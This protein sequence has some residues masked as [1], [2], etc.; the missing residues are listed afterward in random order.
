MAKGLGA[1]IKVANICKYLLCY[2][3]LKICWG[4]GTACSTD[5]SPHLTTTIIFFSGEGVQPPPQTTTIIF[6][7]GRGCSPHCQQCACTA[8][9]AHVQLW[10]G[11]AAPSPDHS[12]TPHHLNAITGTNR[13]LTGNRILYQ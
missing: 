5:P 10:G 12:P 11:G 8:I 1:G 4:G 3:F 13:S 6:F 2:I 9:N 7:L